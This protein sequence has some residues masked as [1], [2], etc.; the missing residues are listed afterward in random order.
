MHAAA[1]YY[2]LTG[3]SY[4]ALCPERSGHMNMGYWPAPSLRAAQESLVRAT[5]AHCLQRMPTLR[6]VLDAGSGWGG[7]A[8][9]FCEMISGVRYLGVNVTAEQVEYAR[10]ANAD[11]ADVRYAHGAIEEFARDMEPV[12]CCVSIEA[13]FHFEAKELLLARLR[14]KVKL[15]TFM[16]ICVEDPAPIR[17]NPLLSAL[18]N[19]WSSARYREALGDAGYRALE[20]EDVS[21]RTF[22]SFSS[23]LSAQ[24][25]AGYDESAAI[26]RQFR[27]AFRELSV[28]QRG[29]ALRYVRLSALT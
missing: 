13:A 20:M 10:E 22:A 3:R 26:L 4:R 16:D 21:D 15:L 17:D 19:A 8:R 29:R 28:L 14:D 25:P 18:C 24:R 9:L 27:A 7:S 12:D 11:L 2:A 6:S 23:H 5:A 1:R